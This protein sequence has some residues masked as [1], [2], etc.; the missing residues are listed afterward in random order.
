LESSNVPLAILIGILS[1]TQLHLAKALERQGIEVFD[2]LRAKLR[3]RSDQ[4]EG[5]MKKP[6]I[7]T[8]GIIL[9]NT[10]FIY[11][12]IAQRYAPPA[13]YTSMF[14]VGLIFLMLYAWKVL[15]EKITPRHAWASVAIIIGTLV[16]GVEN[17]LHQDID[18]FDMSLTPTFILVAAFFI[19]GTV[20]MI[21]SA[22]T[23]GSHLI[24]GVF[25]IFCGG[26]GSLD[27]FLKGIAQNIRGHPE[28]IPGSWQGWAVFLP[29]FVIGF[30]SFAL[31]QV[32]FA[33]KAP[34]SVFVP[35]Y[36]ASYILL[37]VVLQ[38]IL[39]PTYTLYWSTYLGIALIILG[40]ALMRNVIH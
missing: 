37:P 35:V 40:I 19:L 22:R 11:A 2:Q 33:K 10:I 14:G 9:N 26:Y 38:V 21:S 17:I 39:L 8:V 25:G 32:A 18:R 16:L 7:Y 20:A 28:W 15:G 5:G 6:M 29:S 34:A 30:L 36:N 23:N 27:P 1:T 31:T 13:I 4:T 24:A 3:R 12:I